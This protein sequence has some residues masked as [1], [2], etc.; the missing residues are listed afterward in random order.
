MVFILLI[1]SISKAIKAIKAIKAYQSIS[2]HIKAIKAIKNQKMFLNQVSLNVTAQYNDYHPSFTIN[3]QPSVSVEPEDE[4]NDEDDQDDAVEEDDTSATPYNDNVLPEWCS[5][6][7]S[8]VPEWQF[9]QPL[10]R[11][12]G[13]DGTEDLGHLWINNEVQPCTCMCCDD[14]C[15][16]TCNVLAGADVT[17][18]AEENDTET[19]EE[20]SQCWPP[21]SE[22]ESLLNEGG[23][24]W[25]SMGDQLGGELSHVDLT[26][27]N[28]NPLGPFT[29]TEVQVQS[30]ENLQEEW[31][32]E[33]EKC[34]REFTDCKV[35]SS[36][37]D[38][39]KMSVEEMTAIFL[40]TD[41]DTSAPYSFESGDDSD[42]YKYDGGDEY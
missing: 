30:A 35:E 17:D 12:N 22:S 10:P 29:M 18:G 25:G 41:Y 5:P 36:S 7:Q 39:S 8:P 19:Y 15:S 40:S 38:L 26:S 24:L 33:F 11:C 31:A 34:A 28:S 27:P 16:G 14:D 37:A 20:P 23:L 32:A 42:G 4:F 2:K 9:L 1:I 6:P 3:Q 21:E 13:C